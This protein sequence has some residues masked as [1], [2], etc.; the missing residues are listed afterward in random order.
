MSPL[1]QSP[2]VPR[3]DSPSRDCAPQPLRFGKL[4]FFCSG[5]FS[6]AAEQAV[7]DNIDIH[8]NRR[9]RNMPPE[10]PGPNLEIWRDFLLAGDPEHELVEEFRMMARL[11]G[12][13]DQASVSH[14]M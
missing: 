11:W 13:R 3:A 10:C 9:Q 1:C 2:L 6:V 14:K 12:P 4:Q 5:E 7:C 8:K